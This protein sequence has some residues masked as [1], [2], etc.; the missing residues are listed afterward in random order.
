M[1]LF[2]VYKYLFCEQNQAIESLLYLMRLGCNSNMLEDVVQL[3][4]WMQ[5]VKGIK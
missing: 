2:K 3:L 5:I 4:I 1:L